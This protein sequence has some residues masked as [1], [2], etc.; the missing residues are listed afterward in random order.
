M[1]TCFV[2]CI[3]FEFDPIVWG[4]VQPKPNRK[5]ML[6]YTKGNISHELEWVNLCQLLSILYGLG[7]ALFV[8][9][10]LKGI[11][12]VNLHIKKNC[13][14]FPK[15][16]STDPN[17]RCQY[18]GPFWSDVAFVL[19]KLLS[20]SDLCRFYFC[21]LVSFRKLAC[22]EVQYICL[23]RPKKIFVLDYFRAY[24]V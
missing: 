23:F 22:A 3:K 6:N 21:S 13:S 14:T 16:C 4:I 15:P 8:M 24:D 1:K 19:A 2:C 11:L 20:E 12:K 9:L 5:Q 7:L 10:L 18:F 17:C